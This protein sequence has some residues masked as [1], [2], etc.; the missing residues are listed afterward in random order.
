[1]NLNEAKNVDDAQHQRG[2]LTKYKFKRDCQKR[3]VIVLSFL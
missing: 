1:L 2:F 3:E